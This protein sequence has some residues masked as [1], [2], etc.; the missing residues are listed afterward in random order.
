MVNNAQIASLP[1]SLDGIAARLGRLHSSPVTASRLVAL[2]GDAEYELDE[3]AG[4]LARDP[5][6]A[7][8]VLRMANSPMAGLVQPVSSLRLAV[9]FLGRRTIRLL[10]LTFT[11]VDQFTKGLA[12]KM[13]RDYWRRALTISAV[14]ARL[15]KMTG[16]FDPHEGTAAGLLADLGMLALAQT[17]GQDYLDLC[18]QV[19]H[20][21][22][23]VQREEELYGF[24][25]ARLGA[26]LLEEWNLPGNLAAAVARHHHVGPVLDPLE[27][28]V[29]AGDLLANL[30]WHGASEELGGARRVLL[31]SLDFGTNDLIDLMLAVKDDLATHAATFDMCLSPDEH[32][33]LEE[34]AR[35]E[36][37]TAALEM[38]Q[39]LDSLTTCLEDRRAPGDTH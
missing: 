22:R 20:G 14:A 9:I 36:F 16:S 5:A 19:P 34:T 6:L 33:I 4:T 30:L 29:A 39:D 3:V 28:A 27:A 11:F 15:G 37:A 24:H 12:E 35:R 2:C 13:Y 8:R 7:A 10:A 25:H 23:L 18:Q 17:V 1:L 31:A 26:R 21:R 38:A 32:R